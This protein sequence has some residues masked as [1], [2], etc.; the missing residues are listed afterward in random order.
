MD[1]L[2]IY[3]N[4]FTFMNKLANWSTIQPHNTNS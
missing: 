3:I 1:I 4:D 2:N